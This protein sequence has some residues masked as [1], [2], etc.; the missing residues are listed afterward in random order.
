M[1]V[2]TFAFQPFVPEK[3]EE[4]MNKWAEEN[5]SKHTVDEVNVSQTYSMATNPE[6]SELQPMV[7]FSVWYVEKHND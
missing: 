7:M 3:A 6:T 4:V 2:K 5:L 1:K